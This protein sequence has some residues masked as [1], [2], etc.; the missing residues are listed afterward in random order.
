[1]NYR[2]RSAG[3]LGDV[4]STFASSLTSTQTELAPLDTFHQQRV[5]FVTR[6]SKILANQRMSRVSETEFY[7]YDKPCMKRHVCKAW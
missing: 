1:M 3:V 4:L 2:S 5:K 6:E 7:I